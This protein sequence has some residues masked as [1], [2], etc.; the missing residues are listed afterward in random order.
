M[1]SPCSCRHVD[2]FGVENVNVYRFYC[3]KVKFHAFS[4]N[5]LVLHTFLRC[6]SPFPL[7]VLLSLF[8]SAILRAFLILPRNHPQ[9]SIPTL[10]LLPHRDS[11][12][13]ASTATTMPLIYTL[14]MLPGKWS[15]I[16]RCAT[17]CKLSFRYFPLQHHSTSRGAGGACRRAPCIISHLAIDQSSLSRR[18][19]VPT[20]NR[21]TSNILALITFFPICYV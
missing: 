14:N 17:L 5:Q 18:S 7:G 15:R 19:T 3:P 9:T 21:D 13:C 12:L 2:T 10:C 20:P 11:L 6:N 1:C 4:W 8:V 16:Y